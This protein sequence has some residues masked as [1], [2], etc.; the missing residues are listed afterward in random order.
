MY[1]VYLFVYIWFF[2]VITLIPRV[3]YK[4]YS[5]SFHEY[6]SILNIIILALI[7]IMFWLSHSAATFKN[8]TG[9]GF[10]KALKVSIN[11]GLAYLKLIFSF[12]SSK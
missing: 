10:V 12:I 9:A 7:I 1:F 5:P 2:S 6:E 3:I 4:M 11:E 8:E